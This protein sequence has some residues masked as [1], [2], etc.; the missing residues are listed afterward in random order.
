[1]KDHWDIN[2]QK[3]GVFMVYDGVPR[4]MQW[5]FTAN[6]MIWWIYLDKFD[7]ITTSLRWNSWMMGFGFEG[8]YP[9]LPSISGSWIIG[10]NL[11]RWFILGFWDVVDIDG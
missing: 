10:V 1:M 4:G 5:E 9:K 8:N 2:R 11:P 7:L 3:I 6:N